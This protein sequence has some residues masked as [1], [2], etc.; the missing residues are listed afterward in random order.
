[1][2]MLPPSAAENASD[3]L[4][5]FW[6]AAARRMTVR[7]NT[8]LK[9]KTA[10]KTRHPI[11]TRSATKVL[12]AKLRLKRLDSILFTQYR[13]LLL[14]GI[15]VAWKDPQDVLDITSVFPCFP[16]ICIND[17]E[18]VSRI[19]G[20]ETIDEWNIVALL[21][22]LYKLAELCESGN[23]DPLELEHVHI[24]SQLCYTCAIDIKE[25][26]HCFTNMHDCPRAIQDVV[27]VCDNVMR[28]A[29]AARNQIE[30]RHI[31]FLE[32]GY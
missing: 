11:M 22:R 19:V 24:L 27:Y 25:K 31:Q 30:K 9:N 6:A 26:A 5:F 29:K 3:A 16:F 15:N 10:L 13:E 2:S 7:K 17:V 8:A 32:T 4:P 20:G 23:H 21:E 1:M 28:K 14:E 18:K 12:I